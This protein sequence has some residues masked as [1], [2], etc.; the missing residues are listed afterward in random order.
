[1]K[2][3]LQAIL[4]VISDPFFWPSMGFTASIG[5]FVGSV[6]YD[7]VLSDLKK[8][9]FSLM[10]YAILI[11]SVSLARVVPQ[12]ATMEPTKVYQPFASIITI[13]VVSIFYGIGT[14]LGVCLTKKAHK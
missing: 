13:F 14:Y 5:V 10:S 4:Y 11:V 1:M 9:L 6:I 12:I 3:L 2:Y 8:M 7:G